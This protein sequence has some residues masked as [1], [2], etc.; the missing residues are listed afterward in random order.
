MRMV[1][2]WTLLLLPAA[3]LVAVPGLSAAEGSLPLAFSAAPG[4]VP[5]VQRGARNFMNY[6]AGC[7]SLEY[8]RYDRLGRDNGIPDSVLQQ[9]L[10]FQTGL[11]PFDPMKSAMTA[12]DG[13][14]FF[15]K[16]P[17]DLTLEAEYKSPQW[18]YNYLHGF[19]LDPSRPTGVNNTVFKDV[20]MPDVLW[21]LQGWQKQ[22]KGANGEARLEL[23]QPGSM[24]PKEYDGFVR[25]LTNFLTYASAPEYRTRMSMGPWVL[26]YLVILTI[27][28]YLVK[29]AFWK[30]VEH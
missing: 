16:A 12:A 1:K 5:S 14:A 9:T 6:C 30:H 23:V 22:V 15:G 3:A 18:I 26:L 29:R 2:L 21:E 4:N 24:T 17:P 20:A 10:M 8:L 19:Y 7:H 28:L 27:L 13:K 11:K 25:D